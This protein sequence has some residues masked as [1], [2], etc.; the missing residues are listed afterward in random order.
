MAQ[1]TGY[2][3]FMGFCSAIFLGSSDLYATSQ[4]PNSISLTP[5]EDL[6]AVPPWSE[7]EN[8]T[9]RVFD[10]ETGCIVEQKCVYRVFN[11]ETGRTVEQKYVFGDI[12]GIL[13]WETDFMPG[14][15]QV[16]FFTSKNSQVASLGQD[17][18]GRETRRGIR[19]FT[20]TKNPER[21]EEAL[22]K[23]RDP[24]AFIACRP[25]LLM[26]FMAKYGRFGEGDEGDEDYL[27]VI[28]LLV[29][30]GYRLGECFFY[31]R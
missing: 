24:D 11:E 19:Y 15:S 22:K 28:N 1:K 2:L 4:C 7:V 6:S 16:A 23:C 12:V 14:N 10:E 13:R 31:R 30:F 3:S 8:G 27:K 5:F 17:L 26:R 21:L 18:S 20:L 29:K 25:E 9:Y